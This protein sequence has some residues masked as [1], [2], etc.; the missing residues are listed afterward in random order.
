MR[1]SLDRFSQQQQLS[2]RRLEEKDGGLPFSSAEGEEGEAPFMSSEA[3]EIDPELLA[4]EAPAKFVNEGVCVYVSFGIS[5]PECPHV[6]VRV[7][8]VDLLSP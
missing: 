7:T 8:A 4:E 1:T 2:R 3:S 5:P 6:V